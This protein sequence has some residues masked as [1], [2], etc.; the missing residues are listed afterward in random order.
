MTNTTLQT[1]LIELTDGR[2]LAVGETGAA[3]GPVVVFLPSAPG[4]R[5]IDP[6]PAATAAAGVRL[7]T[8][9]RPGY[10]GSSPLAE[11]VAPSVAAVA[12][13][14]AFALTQL[15]VTDA[16]VAGWSSGGRYTLALAARHPQLVRSA[17][18]IATPAPDD[19]VPWIQ[20]QHR[21]MLAEMRAD[22]AAGVVGISQ[23]FA[24]IAA[25]PALFLNQVGD[26]DA[27]V[28][29]LRSDPA[30]RDRA[31]AMLVEAFRPG[32]LGVATDIV[33]C[34]VADAGFDATSVGAPVALFYGDAD[35]AVPPPHG[36][37]WQQVLAATTLQVV[38]GGG[39]FIALTH[40]ADVLAALAER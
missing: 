29:A 22:P 32:V 33:A 4:S 39:H 1:H 24:P 6:D 7:L 13:D 25:D 38:P 20:D 36:G 12:D 14:V 35:V 21:P 27:D 17:A 9:D 18:L 23:A 34:N 26:G 11:G 40:W 16:A 8:I 10:G 15:G 28:A 2:T 31:Q 5:L 3:D 30:M 19:D 37:Y